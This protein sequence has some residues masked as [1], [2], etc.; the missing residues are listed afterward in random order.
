MN[1]K[2]KFLF[3]E[4]YIEQTQREYDI[5]LTHPQPQRGSNILAWFSEA[6]TIL[7]NDRDII[8]HKLNYWIGPYGCLVSSNILKCVEVPE[9]SREHWLEYYTTYCDDLER[10]VYNEK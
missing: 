1:L 8:L 2:E 9:L 3:T 7:L 6:L 10:Y 4:K 5:I